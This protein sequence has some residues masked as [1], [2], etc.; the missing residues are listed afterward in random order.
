MTTPGGG[1]RVSAFLEVLFTFLRLGLTS[2][3]GPVAHLAYFRAELVE[4]RRWLGDARYSELL[5]LCQFLPGPASSQLGMALGMTRAGLWG[6]LAAWVGFTLP[7]AA[8]LLLFAQTLSAHPALAAAGWVHGLKVVAVAVVA[9]A[10]WAMARSLCPDRPRAALAM[11]AALFTLLAPTAA[12]QLVALLLCGLLGLWWLRDTGAGAGAS[13]ANEATAAPAIAVSR[14]LAVVALVVFFALLGVLSLWAAGTG[15]P[16][17]SAMSGVY[18]AGALVFGGGHVVLP[19]LEASV[20]PAGLVSQGDFLAGYGAAQAV[21]GP[22]FSFAAYLGALLP[23]TWHG[24]T[25]ALLLLCAIFLP[26]FLVLLGTLPFWEVLRQRQGM[27]RAMAGVN[28]GVVGL[29]LSALYDP[30]WTGAIH[31]RA[32]AALALAAW[33]LLSLARLPPVWVVAFAA[34]AGWALA[35]WI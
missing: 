12:A 21:P 22:L 35:K 20:V 33:A 26:G 19:L 32:D 16:V 1:G 11:L 17:L 8:A 3:G 14:S 23:G 13:G 7:S 29:L 30:V 18:R 10:V 27:R 15:S 31:S 24:M 2:F 28:A 34:A 6:A 25:G 4:R 9:Q 5:A